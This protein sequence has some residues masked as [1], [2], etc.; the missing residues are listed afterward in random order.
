MV[1]YGLALLLGAVT[2]PVL[3]LGQWLVLRRHVARPGRWIVANAIAW[4]LGMV[5]V[6]WGMD[7]VPWTRG[8]LVVGLAIYLVCGVAGVVVGA[9]HG[10]FLRNLVREARAA[11]A[12]V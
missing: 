2:G 11:R 7:Q 12:G 3:G 1:Q 10:W 4:A 9:T 6:F 5:V 8:G